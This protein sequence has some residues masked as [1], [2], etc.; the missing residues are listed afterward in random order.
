MQFCRTHVIILMLA[1]L[2]AWASVGKLETVS[3]VSAVVTDGTAQMTVSG[4]SSAKTGMTV[5]MGNKEFSVS[6]VEK[7]SLGNTV[8]YALVTLSNGKYDAVI[9]TESISPI[10]FLFG[11]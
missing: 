7:D 8:V 2:F 9:V 3:N 10:S 5:R 4:S 11:S 1:G 6:A